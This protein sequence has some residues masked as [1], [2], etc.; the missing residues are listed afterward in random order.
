LHRVRAALLAVLAFLDDQPRWA[1]ILL[2]QGPLAQTQILERRRDMQ[3]L[4]ARLLDQDA[5]REKP[6]SDGLSPLAPSRLTADLIIGGVFSLVQTRVADREHEPLIKLAPALMSFLVAPYLGEVAASVE[7]TRLNG[8]PADRLPS[9]ARLAVRTTYRTARVL[10]AI[11]DTPRRNNR[12]VADA[13]GLSD[14]GQTSKLLARLERRGVIENVGLGAAHG[15][16]NA[17]LLTPYGQR[18]VEAI[19]HGFEVSP[20]VQGA[21]RVRGAA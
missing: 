12:E 7:Q 9:S 13:A 2:A 18:V 1:P 17:W 6:A 14:E 8:T 5:P 4:L 15:E 3:Q 11:C 20:A 10:R 16:P 19:G 21:R